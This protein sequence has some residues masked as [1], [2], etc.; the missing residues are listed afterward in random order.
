MTGLPVNKP[1]PCPRTEHEYATAWRA[2][3]DKETGKQTEI[4]ACPNRGIHDQSVTARMVLR[5]VRSRPGL[6]TD[7]AAKMTGMSKPTCQDILKKFFDA[8]IVSRDRGHARQ[9]FRYEVAS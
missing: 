9:P 2:L 8:G 4:G 6:T 3:R 5:A 1:T 7:D